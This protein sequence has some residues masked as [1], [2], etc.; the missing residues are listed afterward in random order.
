MKI[1]PTTKYICLVLNIKYQN[2]SH[3]NQKIFR[4]L[5]ITNKYEWQWRAAHGCC[6][7][8]ASLKS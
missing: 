8:G 3:I 7:C 5:L 4:I 1:D 6:G 2:L